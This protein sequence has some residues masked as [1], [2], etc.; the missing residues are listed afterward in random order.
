M[1]SL[2]P[3]VY[4]IYLLGLASVA[5]FGARYFL[6]EK[7]SVPFDERNVLYH[8]D[9]ELGWF[10]APNSSYRYT[11]AHR[12]TVE[13]NSLGFRDHEYGPKEKPR[14]AFIGDSFLWGY[15]VEANQRFTERL[16]KEIPDWE[17]LNLGVSGFGP[18][19]QLLLLR[20]YLNR[21]DPDYVFYL[22]CADNDRADSSTNIVYGGYYKPYFRYSED[23]GLS[24]NGVPVPVSRLHYLTS[25]VF[26]KHSYFIRAAANLVY[27]T[28]SEPALELPNIVVP[29]IGAL[30]DET[31]KQGSR[32]LLGSTEDDELPGQAAGQFSIPYISFD[33]AERFPSHGFHWTPEGHQQVASKL[34]RFLHDVLSTNDASESSRT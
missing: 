33:G 18:D 1:R 22:Y 29:L 8:H 3:I 6:R 21:L 16:Q 20:R 32:F 12:I 4:L 17:V 34:Q 14:I 19:Q 23:S 11:G 9:S 25:G 27:Q 10:A 5:E 7:L 26:S 13:T 2:F 31:E 15:D 30:K 24:L 28:E